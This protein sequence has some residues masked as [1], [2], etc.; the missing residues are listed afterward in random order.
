MFRTFRD[1]VLDNAEAM[2]Y[3]IGANIWFARCKLAATF[4]I[5]AVL[6]GRRAWRRGTSN[7]PAWFSRN[8]AYLF[9]TAARITAPGIITDAADHATT[10]AGY[11]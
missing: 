11:R 10:Q 5:V 9:L 6:L 3:E 1:F 2:R 4:G 7:K 8:A